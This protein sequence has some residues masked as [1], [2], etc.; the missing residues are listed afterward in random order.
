M[1]K[2]QKKRKSQLN[3]YVKYSAFAVQ[4]TIVIFFAYYLGD[5][6]DNRIRQEKR[7]LT[8]I[9]SLIAIFGSLYWFFCKIKND[10][11]G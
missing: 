8:I 6:L 7:A 11:K 4:I 2:K 9:F 1:S 3:L 5:L 10:R